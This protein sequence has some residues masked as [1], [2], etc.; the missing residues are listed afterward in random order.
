M[1]LLYAVSP[2]GI[3]STAL[4]NRMF[5][6]FG[7]S[8]N[9]SL[10][11]SVDVPGFRVADFVAFRF[12]ASNQISVDLPAVAGTRQ[13]EQA[14]L[15]YILPNTSI[16]NSPSREFM[17][18]QFPG[19]GELS[20]NAIGNSQLRLS[21]PSNQE[22]IDF[23]LNANRLYHL[24]FRAQGESS[25]GA[26][27]GIISFWINGQEIYR[28]DAVNWDSNDADARFGDS[29][30]LNTYYSSTD[31]STNW[32][33]RDM[34][35]FEG[36][37]TP[38]GTEPDYFRV[39]NTELSNG[40]LTADNTYTVSQLT[41]L[42]DNDDGTFASGANT[43]D[44]LSVNLSSVAANLDLVGG[45]VFLRHTKS[46][47]ENTEVEITVELQDESFQH[48]DTFLSQ[49]T[50]Q[51]VDTSITFDAPSVVNTGLRLE[52]KNNDVP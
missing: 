10:S 12:G 22:F 31:S 15:L 37:S 29:G 49:T 45:A 30:F 39:D 35:L 23:E 3:D 1:N 26:N 24:V 36:W 6:I 48:V 51:F 40:T 8:G 44:V 34:V 14:C 9:Y 47:V 32:V 28:N 25:G 52:V 42:S 21:F 27:D 38:D 43:G 5:P 41:D 18:F 7:G 46:T 4:L 20:V 11:P 2:D 13:Y 17:S 19:V 33:F 16:S 50:N